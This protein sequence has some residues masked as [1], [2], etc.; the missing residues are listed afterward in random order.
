[1]ARPHLYPEVG[2]RYGKLT[3]IEPLP[4]VKKG[5]LSFAMGKFICDCGNEKV[6][7]IRYVKRNTKSCG[8]NYSISN[9]I[10]GIAG[11]KKS[12]IRPTGLKYKKRICN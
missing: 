11:G 6:T 10:N 1:M 2:T 3:F 12:K 4:P 8:C 9:A 5:F 7:Q